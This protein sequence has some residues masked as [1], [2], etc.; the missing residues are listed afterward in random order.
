MSGRGRHENSAEAYAAGRQKLSRRAG[1]VLELLRDKGPATDREI[2]T[3]LR[4]SEPNQ[5]RPRICELIELGD[6]RECGT[7]ICA[8]TKKRV[9]VVEAVPVEPRQQTMFDTNAPALSR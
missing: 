7:K 3:A 1:E 9:R 2:M 5:V 4:F 8:T 6:V